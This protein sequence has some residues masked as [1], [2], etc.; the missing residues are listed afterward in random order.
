MKI[1]VQGG[2][3]GVLKGAEQ[4]IGS[5]G[6][7]V[8][9]AE[10]MGQGS[11]LDFLHERDYVIFDTKFHVLPLNGAELSPDDWTDIVV[12]G[13][14][15]GRS[16]QVAWPLRAPREHM[17]YGDYIREVRKTIGYVWTDLIAVHERVLPA[18]IRAAH[19]AA[20]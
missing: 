8:I 4:T 14:S 5:H 10:F 13:L 3:F 12:R 16:V 11:V 7:D 1:D 2:E 15:S 19:G 9:F 18:F 6:V 17:A 20:N